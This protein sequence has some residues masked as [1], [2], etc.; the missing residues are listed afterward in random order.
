MRPGENAG[1]YFKRT[2]DLHKQDYGKR[3]NQNSGTRYPGGN[4]E[5]D[6]SKDNCD[7]DESNL[8]RNV[9]IFITIVFSVLII[10]AILFVHTN[11]VPVEKEPKN[12]TNQPSVSQPI[13]EQYEYTETDEPLPTDIRLKTGDSPYNS[14]F[15]KGIRD[16]KSL[17]EITVKNGTNQDAV[18]I[19]TN[20]YSDKCMRNAFIRANSNYTIKQIPEGIYKMKCYY[21]NNWDSSLNNGDGFPVGG[22]KRNVY[23][24]T[25]SSNKDYFNMFTEETYNGYNYPTYTVTL[26]KVVNGNMQTKNISKNDFFN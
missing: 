9:F 18:V 19:F 20:A 24:T 10:A 17:S 6:S 3:N 25:P 1:D 8:V 12:H 14:Y 4:K 11:D 21:G 5:H 7:N 2:S 22:F 15:G 23:F 26:H 13:Q 16:S